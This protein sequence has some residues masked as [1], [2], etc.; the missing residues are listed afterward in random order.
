MRPSDWLRWILPLVLLTGC[1]AGAEE[2]STA[3][4]AA[5]TL[6]GAEGC[7]P[8]ATAWDCLLPF[9]SDFLRVEDAA[10]PSGHR[11][12]VPAVAQP[13]AS[14]GTRLDLL[15]G[16][17]VDGFSILQQV[18]VRIPGG[19]DE[20][21]LMGP[22]GE[23]DATLKPGNPTLILDAE[24]GAP[25]PHM[26]ELDPRPKSIDDHSLMLRPLIPLAHDR[27]YVVVVQ[28]LKR[29]DGVPVAAPAEF[30]ALRDET[31]AVGPA[32]EHLAR[33]FEG[34]VF[35][36]LAKAGVTR[37][38]V[39][40]AWDFTT[41]SAAGARSDLL[42]MREDLL[43]AFAQS[44]PEVTIGKV[45]EAPAANVARAVEGTVT[46]PLYLQSDEPGA[47]MT[48]DASGR[49]LA[50]TT[51]QVPFAAVISAAA[52]AQAVT[53]TAPLVQ[54]GHGFFGGRD[55]LGSGP[56]LAQLQQ[57]GGVGFATDWWGLS[58]PDAAHIV[59]DLVTETH[60]TLRFVDRLHQAMVNALVVA[61]A[62]RTTLRQAPAFQ[63]GGEAIAG[64]QPLG[65]YGSSLGHILGGTYVA[66]S[67]VIERAVFG[68]GGAGFGMIMPRSVAFAQLM[69]LVDVRAATRLETLKALLILQIGL[70]RIDPITWAGVLRRDTL[71]G[72]PDARE[73]L[74]QIGVG[75]ASVP[76]MTAHVHARGLDIGH[77]QPAPRPVWGLPGVKGPHDGSALVE[78]DFGATDPAPKAWPPTHAN[79]VH[80]AVRRLKSGVAQITAFLGPIGQI[81][82]TCEGACDPN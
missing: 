42:A 59:S 71:P 10:Q 61:E 56:V 5:W 38:G 18:A 53:G 78:F 62:M 47:K 72:G 31:A 44:A 39:V 51:A 80:E 73:V 65:Y 45:T 68:V 11:I 23:P 79:E 24:T 28:G 52:L 26:A 50:K 36:V 27:R 34:R 46:V 77:L 1:G 20:G 40:L 12:S 76:N 82:Q 33:Y 8:I 74:L 29:P 69:A 66:L 2:D 9:P 32:A 43:A 35:P 37:G 55:E 13:L 67:P 48:R 60:L 16:F 58:T 81:E 6:D 19:L 30:A 64:T 7:N 63:S 14:D 15:A 22:M 41:M 17:P 54:I 4:P 21:D 57:L 25:V 49:P 3:P 75:D 70:E